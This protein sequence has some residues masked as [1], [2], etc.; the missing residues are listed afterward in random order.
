MKHPLFRIGQQRMT[1]VQH[2]R[3]RCAVRRRD[4]IVA[5]QQVEAFVKTARHFPESHAWQAGSRHLE[6]KRISG[7]RPA[8]LQGCVHRLLADAKTFVEASRAFLEK[9]HGF[10]AACRRQIDV[11][12]WNSE[13]F[14]VKALLLGDPKR[15]TRCGD[16]Y[17]SRCGAK[18]RADE[19]REIGHKVF[20]RV[21]HNESRSRRNAGGDS[22]Q[23]CFR[24]P[25]TYL[26]R[27]GER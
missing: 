14:E 3:Q 22:G 23:T 24:T 6:G 26:E 19:H 13:P 16:E 11:L 8:K 2:R 12:D 27:L 4:A 20:T 21:Q 15:L 17:E 1:P 9:A 7:E 25:D 5:A 18:K 10:E